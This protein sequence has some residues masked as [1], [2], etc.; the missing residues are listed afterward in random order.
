M[1]WNALRRLSVVVAAPVFLTYLLSGCG[2][3]TTGLDVCNAGC[4]H[5]QT[6]GRKD[7]TGVA[8]CRTD[9]ANRAGSL[10]DQDN[11]RSKECSNLADIRAAELACYAATAPCNQLTILA[12]LAEAE[13]KCLKK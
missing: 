11:A 13:S 12:C 10:S 9:C 3:A 1:S 5:E 7:Q 4:A 2:S 6:C 8:N